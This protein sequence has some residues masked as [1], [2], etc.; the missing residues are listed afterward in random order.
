[1]KRFK[2]GEVIRM[3]IRDGWELKRTRGD[4][5]QFKHPSKSG[6]VTVSGKM[7]DTIDQGLL[8]SI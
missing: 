4:H 5:R 7:S 1:M 8:S 3:L 6:V 2:V